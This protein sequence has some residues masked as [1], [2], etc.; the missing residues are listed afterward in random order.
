[1][2]GAIPHPQTIGSTSWNILS[3]G[4]AG[5]ETRIITKIIQTMATMLRADHILIMRELGHHLP[6]SMATIVAMYNL[7]IEHA[8]NAEVSTD[9]DINV[10]NK[11]KHTVCFNCGR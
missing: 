3:V 11:V 6:C 4:K 1:M 5:V 9:W 2:A 8:S 7:T 10:A